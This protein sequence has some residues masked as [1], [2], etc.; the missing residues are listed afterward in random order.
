MEIVKISHRRS[1][2]PDNGEDG[3]FITHVHSIFF[4][5]QI[6]RRRGFLSSLL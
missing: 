5:A 1:L 4:F 2:S 3:R 6:R